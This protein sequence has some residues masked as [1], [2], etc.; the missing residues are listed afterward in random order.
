[1]NRDG[2]SY[3]FHAMTSYVLYTS[4]QKHNL[5]SQQLNY[6]E[7]TKSIRHVN[8]GKMTAANCKQLYMTTLR[9]EVSQCFD[10]RAYPLGGGGERRRG[11]SKAQLNIRAHSFND[12]PAR[13]ILLCLFWGYVSI[14]WVVY[15]E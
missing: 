6:P 12:L 2:A 8:N 14:P 3:S 11:T 10:Q 4:V 1:M 7:T 5:W 9:S 13:V 15:A